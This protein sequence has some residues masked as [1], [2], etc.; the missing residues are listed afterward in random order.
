MAQNRWH[1][2]NCTWDSASFNFSLPGDC[3]GCDE[4]RRKKLNGNLLKGDYGIGKNELKMFCHSGIKW[5]R[6]T[7]YTNP[8]CACG[9]TVLNATA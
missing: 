4:M 5:A 3:V 7:T 1:S 8:S 2:K 6:C 9:K